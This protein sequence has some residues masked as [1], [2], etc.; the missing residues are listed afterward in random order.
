MVIDLILERKSGAPYSASQFYR[1]ACAYGEIAGE[2]THAM[3]T[4]INKEIQKA[5]CF[6][7]LGNDYNLEICEYVNAED[8]LADS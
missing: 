6:Y 1:E 8:W 2:I 5:L 3:D 7:V 4:G